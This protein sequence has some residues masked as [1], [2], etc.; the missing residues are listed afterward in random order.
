MEIDKIYIGTSGWSYDSWIEKFYPK[1]I[2]KAKWLGYYSKYFNTVEINSSFYHL[3]KPETFKNW[4]KNTPA[5]FK[6]SVKAS[7]YITHT[8]KL[9]NC[10]DPLENLFE[11]SSW[12]KE[13]L[14]IFLFQLP[15]SLKKDYQRIKNFFNL[16]FELK[17]YNEFNKYKYVFEF[18]DE[19]WFCDEIYELL[20]E[21]GVG[22]VISNSGIFPAH[23]II[24]GN[25]CYIRMH[26]STSLYSSKYNDDELK[27]VAEMSLKNINNNVPTYIYFNND[28]C[29]YAIENAISL[30]EMLKKHS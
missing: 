2:S 14:E 23:N 1:E 17:K 30:Q 26:G 21:Y 5:G 29:G 4:F 11:A 25:F 7:K 20:N 18:R 28:V 27:E 12:L 10:K 6:F 16:L 8:K 22:C 9:L 13:K 19:S 24:T 15:P 3:P